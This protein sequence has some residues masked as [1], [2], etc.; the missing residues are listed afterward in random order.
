MPTLKAEITRPQKDFFDRKKK[1]IKRQERLAGREKEVTN[2]TLVQG[3]IDLWMHSEKEGLK[4]N[5][6]SN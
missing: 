4:P 2:D 5:E 3:L 1:E 6:P